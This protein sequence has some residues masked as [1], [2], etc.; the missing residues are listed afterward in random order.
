MNTTPPGDDAWEADAAFYD[1]IYARHD[2]PYACEPHDHSQASL[3][4]AVAAAAGS[5]PV[6][7]AGCGIGYLRAF[8]PASSTYVGV[9]FSAVAIAR[10]RQRFA[11]TT[12]IQQDLY[13]GLPRQEATYIFCEV[14]EHL[15][16][17]LRVLA[18]VPEGQPVIL[19]VPRT[20]APA[21]V[22]HF[23]NLSEA[24]SRYKRLLD[25]TLATTHRDR[26]HLL[27]GLRKNP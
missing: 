12:F 14:L 25:L 5:G 4:Q 21:H 26:W 2:G 24:T 7:D 8:L 10:A 11:D 9:D 19:T 15:A 1:R 16:D 3:W 23:V 17:D 18:Q 20:D 22:R 27:A 13:D 6:I